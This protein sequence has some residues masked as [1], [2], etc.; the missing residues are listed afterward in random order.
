M[1]VVTALVV[2]A[3]LAGMAVPNLS[4]IVNVRAGKVGLEEHESYAA[5]SLVGQFRTH[6]AAW[7]WV[8][9]DLYLH[10]GVE[11]RPMTEGEQAAGMK[12]SE[13]KEDGEVHLNEANLTT[14]VPSA[15][16]DFRGVFG[17]LE[18]A[19]N[20]Y[21]PMAGHE[22]REPQAALP[23]FRLMTWADPEFEQ[24]WTVGAS[25]MR[26]HSVRDAD[27]FLSEG[28]RA[29]PRSLLLRTDL[30]ELRLVH[31]DAR[32]NAIAMLD[33]VTREG[34]QR[35]RLGEEERD[36]L[37]RA[38]RWQVLGERVAGR[39]TES[40]AVALRGLKVFP[41]DAVLARHAYPPP[42]IL[43]EKAADAWVKARV[44]RGW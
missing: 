28:V 32:E 15:E 21:R 19:T 35:G 24:G 13:G 9:T 23:L 4:P 3:V 12:S 18:R 16:D 36:T 29:N 11:L 25:V 1:R 17:T 27:A 41:D 31:G 40:Q 39:T 14:S 30:A 10:N 8:R 6:V 22:H 5:A 2:A 44:V 42:L 7:L 38:F 34:A 37:L 26:A 43:T 20:A 33:A